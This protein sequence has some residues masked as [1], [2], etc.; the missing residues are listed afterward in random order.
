MLHLLSPG[1]HSGGLLPRLNPASVDR[2]EEVTARGTDRSDA[3]VGPEPS[4]SV[5]HPRR[6]CALPAEP[7][8]RAGRVW[9]CA[10]SLRLDTGL[11]PAAVTC[12]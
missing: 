1:A 7:L 12:C 2:P 8:L 9:T 11:E 5:A 6:R 3:A 4:E 10:G